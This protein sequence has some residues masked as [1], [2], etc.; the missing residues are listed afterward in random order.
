[1]SHLKVMPRGCRYG[2]LGGRLAVTSP[3]P[4]ATLFYE[5]EFGAQVTQCGPTIVG[6][7]AGNE[8]THLLCG[9]GSIIT[10]GFNRK[11]Q[12][13]VAVDADAVYPPQQVCVCALGVLLPLGPLECLR[14]A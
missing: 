3:T 4:A 5:M 13:G 6:V 9:D 1:V 7:Y 12:A 8:S 14:C 2:E 10:M 11:G